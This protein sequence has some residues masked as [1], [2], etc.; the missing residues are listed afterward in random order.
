MELFKSLSQIYN[1]ICNCQIIQNSIIN[2]NSI[3][4]LQNLFYSLCACCNNNLDSYYFI[5][6]AYNSNQ[7]GF[8]RYI[9]NYRNRLV[10]LILCTE[11]KR[12]VQHFQLKNRVHINWNANS[13]CY[14]VTPYVNNIWERQNELYNWK[15]S[16]YNLSGE[17]NI[18]SKSKLL[19]NRY[20]NSKLLPVITGI[21][22]RRTDAA[23]N[24]INNT[25]GNTGN[26]VENTMKNDVPP[27]E[28]Y[29][30]LDIF[31]PKVNDLLD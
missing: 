3:N 17:W 11:S 22:P 23:S 30:P 14:I 15:N 4:E 29:I 16:N 5:R 27:L 25:A 21:L 24:T 9:S 7:E 8:T 6:N 28:E 13:H 1:N 20:H 12:I 31:S 10:P 2:E 19:N 26:V 18:P